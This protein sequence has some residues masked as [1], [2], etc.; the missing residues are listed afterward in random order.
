VTRSTLETKESIKVLVCG[1]RDFNDQ[2]LLYSVLGTLHDGK[3]KIAEL[4]HGAA[5][6]ADQMA[7]AWAIQNRVPVRAFPA[8]WDKHG[9]AAGPIRN[10]QMLREGKPDLV[11]AFPGGR[12]TAHMCRIAAEAGV[13]VWQAE[14]VLFG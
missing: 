9:R 12:G 3:P 14:E 7:G 13:P 8:D 10:E 1:G 2:Y 6:G 5:R 4:I 11:L